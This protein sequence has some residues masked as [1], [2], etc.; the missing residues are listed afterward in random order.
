MVDDSSTAKINKPDTILFLLSLLCIT[1]MYS[2]CHSNVFSFVCVYLR[3]IH[4]A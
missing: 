1:P 3:F 2:E 4:A